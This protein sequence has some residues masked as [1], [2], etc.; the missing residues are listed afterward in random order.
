[1]KIQFTKETMPDELYNALL[2]HFVNEAVGM[3]VEV[4][5]F[6][7]FNNWVVECQVDAKAAVHLETLWYLNIY[8][9]YVGHNPTL[10]TTCVRTCVA[11]RNN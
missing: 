4:N 10:L 8:I 1:M 3:G 11:S 7:Q 9:Q 6:T 2:Q 5:K